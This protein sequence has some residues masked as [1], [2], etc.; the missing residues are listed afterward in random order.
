M[1]PKVP[2]VDMEEGDE[3]EDMEPAPKRKKP[4]RKLNRRVKINN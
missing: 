1:Q 4:I 3:W 2:R